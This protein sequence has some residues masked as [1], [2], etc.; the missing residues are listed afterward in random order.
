LGGTTG[1]NT[2][3]SPGSTNKVGNLLQGLG[4]LLGGNARANTNAPPATN[5]PAP[6]QQQPQQQQPLNN[7]LN[8]FLKP[9]K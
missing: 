9:K 3:A 7:L 8:D 2:N 6:N 4:G 1:A 5:K